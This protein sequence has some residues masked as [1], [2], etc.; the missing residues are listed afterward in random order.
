M[1]GN[2]VGPGEAT[3]QDPP[4]CS[5][6]GDY[7]ARLNRVGD[8]RPVV[9]ECQV[10]IIAAA[11]QRECRVPGYDTHAAAEPRLVLRGLTLSSGSFMTDLAARAAG[12]TAGPPSPQLD[13]SI[14][15]HRPRKAAHVSWATCKACPGTALAR[16]R[17]D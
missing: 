16:I 6:L 10:G 2:R 1:A 14:K 13:C 3:G 4:G 17:W 15:A 9:D 11:V 7:A 8:R 5:A 12:P